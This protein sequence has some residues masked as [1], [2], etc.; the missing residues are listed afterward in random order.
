MPNRAA[1]ILGRFPL[2]VKIAISDHRIGNVHVLSAHI[3]CQGQFDRL[4]LVAHVHADRMA[5][6]N[7]PGL[8]KLLERTIATASGSDLEAIALG[9]NDKILQLAVRQHIGGKLVYGL[10]LHAPHVERRQTKLREFHG[11]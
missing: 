11:L 4:G 1:I 9:V 10:G 8:L 6:R 2:A 7:R 5:G 3:L